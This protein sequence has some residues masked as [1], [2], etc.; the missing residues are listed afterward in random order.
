MPK[1]K[2]IFWRY[3]PSSN[4]FPSTFKYV[5]ALE[6]ETD[7]VPR[8]QEFYC[9]DQVMNLET[10]QIRIKN[11]SA[12]EYCISKFVGW[13][14]ELP[15]VEKANKEEIYVVIH[16]TSFSHKKIEFDEFLDTPNNRYTQEEWY[17]LLTRIEG[18]FNKQK[19]WAKDGIKTPSIYEDQT[20]V[21]QNEGEFK[22]FSLG[23]R[24]YF[25]YH[26]VNNYKFKHLVRKLNIGY[27]G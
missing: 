6:T 15:P 3:I 9:V 4:N 14:L 20:P 23:R 18:R 8:F 7:D 17:D 19:D 26:L 2:H 13:F 12:P 11:H 24:A 27:T 5:D 16:R 22:A 21:F 1:Y 10:G 25:L